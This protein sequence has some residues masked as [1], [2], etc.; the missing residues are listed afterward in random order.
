MTEKVQGFVG[1]A[2]GGTAIDGGA[3]A[4][5]A[6]TVRTIEA[7]DSPFFTGSTA[8]SR[9]SAGVTEDKTVAK[10]SAGVLRSLYLA[11]AGASPAYVK[12]YNKAT[13]PAV[14][15]DVPVAVYLVPAGV[16]QNV[17]LPLDGVTYSAGISFVMVTGSANTDATE[18]PAGEITLSGSYR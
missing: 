14:A 5:S 11:N 9:V 1:V 2:I 6:G 7:T 13:A 15:S 18:V 10:A 17:N 4:S 16:A 8:F 12:F 3:G